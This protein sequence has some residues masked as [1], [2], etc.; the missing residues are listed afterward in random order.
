M[1]GRAIGGGSVGDFGLAS[2][3]TQLGGEE[4]GGHKLMSC[5]FVAT[6]RRIDEPNE[7]EGG[8]RGPPGQTLMD[9][10]RRENGGAGRFH[11]T[12]RGKIERIGALFW[13]PAERCAER[14]A[15]H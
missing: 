1:E 13:R 5:R 7:N 12:W 2:G 3:Q 14:M 4:R 15:R 11:W 9:G 6:K 10:E 8:G